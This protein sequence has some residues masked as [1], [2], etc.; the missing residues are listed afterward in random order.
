MKSNNLFEDLVLGGIQ[1]SKKGK[2]APIN[3]NA[4]E[5]ASSTAFMSERAMREKFLADRRQKM[6]EKQEADTE[7]LKRALRW[8]LAD[9]H[10]ER[11]RREAARLRDI[12]NEQETFV[13]EVD[14][15]LKNKKEQAFLATKEL[16]HVWDSQVYRRIENQIAKKTG[17][18]NSDEINARLCDQ[19][20]KY[21]E[22]VSNKTLFRDIIIE[23]EYNPFESKAAVIKV[24]ARGRSK[25][26]WDGIKDP[27]NEQIEKVMEI[28][29]DKTEVEMPSLAKNAGKAT[30]PLREWATGVIED[31]PHGFAF[32]AFEKSI[33]E[34]ELTFEE[35]Q[36]R[37]KRNIS[38]LTM[39]HYKYARGKEA[40]AK[41]YP[42]GKRC[43]VKKSAEDQVG[44]LLHV[45][46]EDPAKT[47]DSTALN[48]A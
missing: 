10:A 19:M 2:L 38:T 29:Q 25:T 27:L 24:D 47:D 13:A 32:K 3:T 31:T 46:K 18:T 26:V 22:A 48:I 7:A 14:D 37:A 20:E 5:A 28:H 42:K 39:D 4:S 35:K 34:S 33:A 17:E 11:D 45:V 23:S 12:K 44:A 15:F 16:H 1:A 9:A 36:E 41:E 30:L 43:Y 40:L 21:V 6:E 8:R